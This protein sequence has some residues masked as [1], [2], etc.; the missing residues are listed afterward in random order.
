VE[1]YASRPDYLITA[2]GYWMGSPYTF[3]GK[4]DADDDGVV[5]STTLTPT[6][7]GV[8]VDEDMICRLGLRRPHQRVE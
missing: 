8:K 7:D 5:V 1:I 3:L 2:G 6:G 4:G